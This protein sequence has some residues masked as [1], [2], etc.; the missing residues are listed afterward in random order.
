MP[1]LSYWPQTY[2]RT[3]SWVIGTTIAVLQAVIRE[4]TLALQAATRATSPRQGL[5]EVRAMYLPTEFQQKS[6]APG[7]AHDAMFD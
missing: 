4:H 3:H 6:G 2:H 1:H 5:D 7:S